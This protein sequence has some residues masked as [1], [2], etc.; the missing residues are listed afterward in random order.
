[1]AV[2]MERV[3]S[4][5]PDLRVRRGVQLKTCSRYWN[6]GAEVFQS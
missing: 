1:M 3:H 5:A 2:E 4:A 6:G